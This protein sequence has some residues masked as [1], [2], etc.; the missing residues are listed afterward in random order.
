MYVKVIGSEKPLRL[1]THPSH[2]IFPRWSPDGRQIAFARWAPEGSGIYLIPALGGPERKLA[3]VEFIDSHETALSWSP[4]G[5][6]LAYANL[7]HG[8]EGP[9]KSPIM[10]L[11]V[12]GL[13]KRSLGHPSK[14]CQ[15]SWIPAFSPDG[16]SLAVVCIPS[17]GVN[18]LFILPVSGGIGR[19]ITRVENGITGITWTADGASLVFASQNGDLWQVALAGGKPEKLLAGRDAAFPIIS[20]DGRRLAYGQTVSNINIW[21]LPLEAAT[22]GA[23]P[24]VRLV[25]SSRTQWSPAFSPDGRRLAFDSNRSGT[26]E[27]WVSDA[28]G[29]NASPLTAFE[30]PSTGSPKW[31]PDGRFIAFDSRAE[32]RANIYVVRSD[33]GATRRVTTGVDDSS[34]PTWS[35]DGKWL[36][37]AGRVDGADRIFKIPV[38]GGEATRITK[39]EGWNYRVSSDGRRIYYAKGRTIWSVSTEGGDEQRLPGMPGLT[40]EFFNAWALNPSGVYFMN[41]EPLRIEFLDFTSARITRVADIPGRSAPW[42]SLA[43]SPDGRRLL[44]SQIDGITSDIML[45]DNFR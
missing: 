9:A 20:R 11:D 34:L 6:L 41:R 43:L 42:M 31:S 39:G 8:D 3:D 28:D 35:I 22:G 19:R 7:P 4:D 27:I 36:Y 17:S 40:S 5:K 18:D 2:F 10:L 15:W 30:G 26:P 12:T 23:G 21:Q 13:D 14:D 45:I 37:F 24:P 16:R 1:T 33:G 38:E 25:S 29:S 32:G 44:Y